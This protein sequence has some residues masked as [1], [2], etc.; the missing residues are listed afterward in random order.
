MFAGLTLRAGDAVG[1]S[2]L[3]LVVLDA[4]LGVG[5]EAVGRGALEAV[6]VVGRV[7]AGAVVA[8]PVAAVHLG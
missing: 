3:A 6:G 4:V 1:V 7:L 5:E 8:R 2:P